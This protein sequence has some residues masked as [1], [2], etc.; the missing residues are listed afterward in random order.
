M[1][2]N[3]ESEIRGHCGNAPRLDRTMA[4]IL[5][6][7]PAAY[8]LFV[9]DYTL[10]S[11]RIIS[12]ALFLVTTVYFAAAPKKP[13]HFSLAFLAPLL[14]CLYGV[15]QT[16]WSSHM[17]VFNG[18]DKSLFW[19]T[20]AALALLA[21]QA[22]QKWRTAETIRVAITIFGGF[23][24]L[25]DVLQQA[26]HTGKYFGIFKSGFPDV[27]GTFAY[28]NNF[29]QLME[30]TLPITLW[31]GVRHREIR[32][33]YLVL[34]SLQVGAVVA[35]SSRAGSALVLVELILV[36]SLAWIKGRNSVSLPA[37]ALALLLCFGFTFVAGFH[38]VVEKLERPDQLS[39][40]RLI[41]ESSLHMIQARPLTGWG[42]GSYV[43][44]YRMFALYDD[45]TWVNQAHNDYLEW[46]AEGG[47]PY[48][49]IMLALI[50][51]SVRP[52]VRS[53]WGIGLLA[54]AAHALVDY[55]FARLGT[56]GWY[57]VLAA[58]LAAQGREDPEKHRRSRH[59]SKHDRS[60]AKAEPELA[61][62]AN[63]L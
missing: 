7:L 52:A 32:I 38:Q 22:F 19:F 47:I 60:S 37:M 26:A 43:P 6:C 23:E 9:G 17:I 20:V 35:S 56:C 10:I 54:F 24:A 5:F 39:G 13:L 2:L 8:S 28:Y 58:M 4:V 62:T 36:L 42:L 3:S 63:P 51:W 18:I 46:A 14:M 49:L 34:A 61:S 30:L 15:G 50:V 59:G 48:A 27:F 25:L 12:S 31:E 41:N 44:V 29:A 21:T 16:I 1:A 57:F 55:P 33:P 45:G 11:V 40:R 53:I